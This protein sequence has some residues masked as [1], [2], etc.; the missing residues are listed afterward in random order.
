MVYAAGAAFVFGTSGDTGAG[1][2]LAIGVG[3]L[4]IGI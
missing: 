3:P 4:A 1:I 2:G